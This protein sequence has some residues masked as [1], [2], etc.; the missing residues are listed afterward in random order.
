MEIRRFILIFKLEKKI[1]DKFRNK[2]NF[3]I[4]ILPQ[5][6]YVSKDPGSIDFLHHLMK[7]VKLIN[8]Y[9]S[10][11]YFLIELSFN[12]RAFLFLKFLVIIKLLRVLNY[13]CKNVLFDYFP[14][15]LGF[16][17]IFSKQIFENI[18]LFFSLVMRFFRFLIRP[19]S[20]LFIIL[21]R[22]C[23]FLWFYLLCELI[24]HPIRISFLIFLSL[25]VHELFSLH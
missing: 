16:K 3:K 7:L 9:C 25:K 21:R 14:F 22:L 12:Y 15:D 10:T 11:F 2:Q 23:F 4:L 5:I 20:Y 8:Y 13:L 18:S 1:F 17:C 6:S 24:V 19:L